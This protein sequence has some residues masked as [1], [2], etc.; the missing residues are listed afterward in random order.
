VDRDDPAYKGQ[1]AFT[2]LVL[3]LYDPFVL[4][5]I[6]R[7]GW[8]CPASEL[9]ERYRA[10]IRPNHLD[11]GP[12]TGW[13]LARSGLPEGSAITI[14]D[15]NRNVLDHTSRRLTR[16]AVTVVE[17]DVCKPLPV[18]GPFDSAALHLVLH[19]LPGPPERK[20]A[21]IGH[22]AA[23]LA[24]GGI[25]FG[26][27]VLGA[28]A[29]HSW[30]ARQMLAFYNRQGSFDNAEDTEDGLRQMLA[31]RFD[32]VELEVIGSIAVFA[33]GDR[34]RRPPPQERRKTRMDLRFRDPE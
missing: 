5:P 31:A 34:A 19:C 29:S 30:A 17:A 3:D 21:A 4:G 12:G 25:L 11:V 15:P 7:Y 6:A 27:S 20:A 23:T 9:L 18:A 22:V 13:F 10:R 28:S 16:Y 1:A 24:P 2:R 26:A 33:A 8:R 32:E 14:V